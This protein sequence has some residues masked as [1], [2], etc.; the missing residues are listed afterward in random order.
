MKLIEGRTLADGVENRRR[1]RLPRFL[2]LFEAICQTVGFAHSKGI[3]HRDLKPANVMVGA[4]G[5][6]Q[7]MDWGLAKSCGRAG[8]RPAESRS[9]C[10]RRPLGGRRPRRWPGR[11]RARR[12]TWRRSRRAGETVD[13]RADVFALG[14]ILAGD[15]HRPA[16]VRRRHGA[17]HR[18][19]GG[20]SRPAGHASAG[21][22]RAA[23]TRNSS[24]SPSGAS[25]RIGPD[26]PR[27]A[28]N[29]PNSSPPTAPASSPGCVPPSRTGRFARRRCATSASG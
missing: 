28:A 23:P 4:F 17:R 14:G 19:D 26:A 20:A 1:A 11:S 15:P 27:A 9:G 16:A 22:T 2:G 29:S 21:S 25:I 6:V 8:R 7:V 12:R 10:R 18:A 24:R 3:I 5:E 13:A